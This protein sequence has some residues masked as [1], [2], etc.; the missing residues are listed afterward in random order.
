MMKPMARVEGPQ[1][2]LKHSV[3]DGTKKPNP[4]NKLPQ[5]T[6]PTQKVWDN[7]NNRR[8]KSSSPTKSPDIGIR[9]QSKKQA[10]GG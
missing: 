9:E 3:F 5:L 10:T 1:L 2:N 7:D 6:N 4:M 8:G